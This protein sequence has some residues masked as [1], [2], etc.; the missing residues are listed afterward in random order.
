MGTY[1]K[2]AYKYIFFKWTN[3]IFFK[4]LLD[5][6]KYHSLGLVL[7]GHFKKSKFL[8]EYY[9]MHCILDKNVQIFETTLVKGR[10]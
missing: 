3:V 8:R 5:I 2:Y 4:N 1:V 9:L 6:F 10:Y 7:F